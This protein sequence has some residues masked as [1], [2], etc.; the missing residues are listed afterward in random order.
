M[1][2]FLVLFLVLSCDNPS[3]PD[4]SQSD[5]SKPDTAQLE[6]FA[7]VPGRLV[8]G[9]ASFAIGGEKGAFPEG[10]AVAIEPFYMAK[11]L[12]VWELWA[13]VHAWARIRGFV[14]G[15]SA[16]REGATG[17][18]NNLWDW[19]GPGQPAT[20]VTVLDAMVW[21]NAHSE[22][23]GRVPVYYTPEGK[24]LRSALE[25]GGVVIDKTKSGYRLPTEAEWEYAARGGNPASPEWVYRYAGSSD[26]DEV[27]WH[28]GNALGHTHPVG[29]KKPNSLGLYDMIGNE[30]ELCQDY[31]AEEIGPGTPPGGPSGKRNPG[32]AS[33]FGYVVRGGNYAESATVATR[34]S[35]GARFGALRLV[36]A[37][38]GAEGVF[39]SREIEL[40][41]DYGSRRTENDPPGPGTYTVP[42]GRALVLAP[43]IW[44]DPASLVYEWRVDGELQASVTEYLSFTPA[45]QKKY[46]VKVTARAPGGFSGEAT[47]LVECAAPEGTHRRHSGPQSKAVAATVFEYIQG[48]GEFIGLYPLIDNSP[49][50]AM[51]EEQA[52]QIAQWYLEGDPR[53][54][55]GRGFWDAW[56]LGFWGGYGIFGFDHSVANSGG[57]DIVFGSNSFPGSSEPGIVWVMQDEN[58]NGKPDDMWHELAGSRTPSGSA[59][60]KRYARTF[61]RPEPGKIGQYRDNRGASGEYGAGGFP[62]FLHADRVAYTGTRFENEG[63]NM[64]YVD[65]GSNKFRISDA[66]QQDGTPVHLAYIDFVKV[67]DVVGG[68]EFRNPEDYHLNNPDRLVTGISNGQGGQH[69]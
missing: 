45:E 1:S 19:S 39:E 60:G 67:Q 34:K 22:K 44:G 65:G 56:S 33:W 61:Y 53:A 27:A 57:Y 50:T 37:L 10:R 49:E 25:A 55:T 3:G 54:E 11:R 29:K 32:S 21:C 17:N 13:E 66:V 9:S 18:N 26:I 20:G 41:F 68:T 7:Y 48:P 15:E 2:V 59:A 24:A 69:F 16:A 58:G 6:G 23:T 5:A 31:Y 14:F 51:T 28:P 47:T 12:V 35:T 8:Q 4:A 36:T 42:L 62:Y 43:V 64:G 63:L 30:E 40:Y 46:T 38:A 52:R